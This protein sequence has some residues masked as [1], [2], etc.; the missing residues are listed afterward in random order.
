VAIKIA[1]WNVEGRLSGY[2]EAGR[3]SA[4]H[5]L[6]SIE[7]LD[8]DVIILPE[9]YL[10]EVA[11]GVDERL[12]ELG[13]EWQDVEYGKD[14]RDWSEEYLGKIPSLRVMSRLAIADVQTNYWGDLRPMLSFTT[15]D[16]ETGKN[17]RI[18][19]THLDDRNEKLRVRQIDDAIPELQKTELAKVA[20]GDFNAMWRTGRARLIGS[21]VMRFVARHVPHK[22]LRHTLTRLTDM[23]SGRVL[24]RLTAETG[25]RDADPSHKATTT[26]KMRD[27][28]FMP[29]VRI[30]QIDH[31]MV[32]SEIEVDDFAVSSDL[33]SDHRA[34]SMV[35]KVKD[36]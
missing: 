17:V 28:P 5:I 9:A 10:E 35:I 36:E 18:F 24:Q 23:A 16:P 19:A 30:A 14:E 3:G 15:I 20:I 11:P 1:S 4:E 12:K 6:D 22:G 33:G 32:S 34:I 21:S 2:T 27:L 26:P 8:S 29:S 25:L 7:S 13:Y 31:A